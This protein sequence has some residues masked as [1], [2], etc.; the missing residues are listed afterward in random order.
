MCKYQKLSSVLCSV[1][2]CVNGKCTKKKP[3]KSSKKIVKK[4]EG[5]KYEKIVKL[6]DRL[7]YVALS[8]PTLGPEII[9]LSSNEKPF[10]TM[11]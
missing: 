11:K 7:I 5:K 1:L 6:L 4:I 3:K 2:Y 9:K 10:K 8:K